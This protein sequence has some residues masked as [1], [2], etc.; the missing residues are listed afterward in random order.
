M[1]SIFTSAGSF[2]AATASAAGPRIGLMIMTQIAKM[3]TWIMNAE[4]AL[5]K[6]VYLVTPQNWKNQE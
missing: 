5:L 3:M 1:R 6:K 2:A 4:T